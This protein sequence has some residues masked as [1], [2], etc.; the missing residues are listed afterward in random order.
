LDLVP[1]DRRREFGLPP[2]ASWRRTPPSSTVESVRRCDRADPRR[3]V[4]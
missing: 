2:S 3:G 4:V 1:E